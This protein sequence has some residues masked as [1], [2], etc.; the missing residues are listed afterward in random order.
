M[1]VILAGN[2]EQQK[3]YLGRLLEEPLIAVSMTPYT[4]N[5]TITLAEQNKIP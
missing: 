2:K 1:P 3:K 5:V 4:H